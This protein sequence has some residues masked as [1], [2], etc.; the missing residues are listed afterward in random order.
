MNDRKILLQPSK[1]TYFWW[2]T[3]GVFLIPVLG[4]GLILIY[5]K[6]KE[7][8]TT[9]YTITD[10]FIETKTP[11][12]SEKTDLSNIIK[13]PISQSWIEKKFSIG[14]IQL[15]T[16]S[17]KTELKGIKNPGQVADSILQAAEAERLRIQE[18]QKRKPE[19]K[20]I[21]MAGSIDRLETLTGLWQQGLITNEEFKAERKNLGV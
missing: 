14:T 17:K 1:A 11:D 18:K 7:L 20:D 19:R 5:L 4:L 3:L 9:V 2:F 15:Q 12:F 21:E 6:Y 10:Y 13:A 8:N 16:R